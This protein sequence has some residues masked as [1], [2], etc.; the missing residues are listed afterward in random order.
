M[1]NKKRD[2]RTI[3]LSIVS[4]LHRMFSLTASSYDEDT[5]E[6]CN[7]Y[8]DEDETERECLEWL[9]ENFTTISLLA[10]WKPI[11]PRRRTIWTH[12]NTFSEREFL[13]NTITKKSF[14]PDKGRPT[15]YH[16]LK[17]G[18]R[19]V[20]FISNGSLIFNLR[21]SG[22]CSYIDWLGIGCRGQAERW[23]IF[24]TD[25]RPS[26]AHDRGIN[27]TALMSPIINN[28]AESSCYVS[29]AS[30][31]KQ[32]GAIIS[33]RGYVH[34]TLKMYFGIKIYVSKPCWMMVRNFN[35]ALPSAW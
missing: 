28:G 27:Q 33:A 7:A 30:G 9:E 26:P 24:E 17:V 12:S 10:A 22:Q 5:S 18:R 23:N 3:Y 34:W 20:I 31:M 16:A 1:S 35:L 15:Q 8:Q 2:F 29:E 25:L 21:E 4:V 32:D 11:I 6:N 13:L 14:R 19:N